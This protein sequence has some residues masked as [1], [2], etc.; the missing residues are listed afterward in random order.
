MTLDEIFKIIIGPAGAAFIL[1]SAALWL[2]RDHIR[3]DRK[4]EEQADKSAALAEVAVAGWRE[5]TSA[6]LTSAEANEK[7]AYAIEIISEQLKD[8]SLT[9]RR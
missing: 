9:R 8:R 3:R 5:Q 1:L 4:I 2:A 7:A 6:S